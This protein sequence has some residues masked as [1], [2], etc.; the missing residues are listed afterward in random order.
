MRH[1][2]RPFQTGQ[3]V[4]VAYTILRG[5][6]VR[7][8]DNKLARSGRHVVYKDEE[9]FRAKFDFSFTGI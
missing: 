4:V 2:L 1:P 8:L 5:C 3:T 7:R 6:F 9:Q